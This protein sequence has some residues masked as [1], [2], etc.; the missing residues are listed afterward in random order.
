MSVARS[1]DQVLLCIARRR[2][3]PEPAAHLREL[4][5]ETLDWEYLLAMAERHC[6]IPLL[7]FHLTAL[8]ASP[9]SPGVMSRL[10]DASYENTR[11]SL[12]L[13]GELI[14]VLEF[15]GANG[16]RAIPFKGPTLAMRAYGDV[17][18][19]QFGDLDV[20]VPKRDVPQVKKLLVRRGFS[21]TPALNSAQQA[22]LLK[23]DC[24]Y[25]FD[26]GQ[27][28][29]LDVH[30]SLVERHSSFAFDPDPFWDRLE[31]VTIGGKELLTL[32]T[33]DLLLILCLH[34]FT[35]L[36]ERLG[37]ICDVASLIDQQENIDWRLVM[38]NANKLGL[39]RILLLG[40]VLA[41]ELLDASLP[42]EMRLAADGDAVVKRLAHQVEEQLFR[43]H[44]APP[45]LFEGAILDLKMRERKRDRLRS[46][47]CLILTPRSYDWMSLS[48]PES[49]FFLYYLLRP[50]RL[51]RKYGLQLLWGSKARRTPTGGNG[52][53]N[54]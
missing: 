44:R 51:A 17:G 42:A 36:W 39:R 12:S 4:L 41:S 1:E 38:E 18:L 24:A 31:P 54:S 45:G 13:T 26:N 10:Q 50:V 16:I 19:R 27:G 48:L 30:W 29:V 7:H 15:L 9:I 28:V 23:F 21:P 22:A 47:V 20:L 3:D 53:S 11:S 2:L 46:G 32:S 6:L 34:G 8:T 5:Q 49:L 52:L 37:W 35:H 33:E 43:E 25:N 40:L 14:K